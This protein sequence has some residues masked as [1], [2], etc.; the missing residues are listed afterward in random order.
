MLKN[1]ILQPTKPHTAVEI[2]QSGGHKV[3][4][5]SGRRCLMS[6]CLGS[7]FFPQDE[8]G[9]DTTLP[10]VHVPTPIHVLRNRSPVRFPSKIL[11]WAFG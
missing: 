3:M 2:A 7:T 4:S 5:K 1:S 9:T 11:M 8:S 6:I 10:G